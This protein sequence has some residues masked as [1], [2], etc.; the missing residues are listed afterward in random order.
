[1]IKNIVLD[2]GNVLIPFSCGSIWI[3]LDFQM[4]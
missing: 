3:I 2:I 4:K 1:M